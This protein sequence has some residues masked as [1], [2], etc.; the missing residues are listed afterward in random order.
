MSDEGEGGEV[1][2]IQSVFAEDPGQADIATSHV[3]TPS[4]RALALPLPER[5]SIFSWVTSQYK[6]QTFT[7]EANTVPD[8]TNP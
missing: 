6:L 1:M 7:I 2:S 5:D 3:A 4:K 8:G